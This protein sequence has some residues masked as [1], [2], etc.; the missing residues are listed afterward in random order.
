MN[1]VTPS[2]TCVYAEKSCSTENPVRSITRVQAQMQL[3]NVCNSQQWSLVQL[4]CN[5]SS[6]DSQAALADRDRMKVLDV[7]GVPA[8]GDGFQD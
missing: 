3:P 1:K 5:I 2:C 6:S 8:K 4:V 7:E